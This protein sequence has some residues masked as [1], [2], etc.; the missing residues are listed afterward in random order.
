MSLSSKKPTAIQYKNQ[1]LTEV[2]FEIRFHGEPVVESRRHEFFEKVRGDYPLL[3]VPPFREGIHPSLQ[4]Y[5]FVREDNTAGVTLALNSLGYFQKEYEGAKKYMEEVNRVVRIANK[6]FSIRKFSRIGWRYINT[7]AFTRE[8]GLIPLSYY[9][10]NPPSF[11]T[12][13]SHGFDR[14][15][16]EA[17]TKYEGEYVSVKLQADHLGA[18]GN[19][20]LT[21]DI[22]VYQDESTMEGFTLNRVPGVLERLH[23]IARNFFEESITDDY[24][25]YLKGDT[26]E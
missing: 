7:I 19:E 12:I 16:F 17:T 20:L 14:V 9:F 5:R 26:Y 11:F 23:N 22:D 15:D 3:Y 13:E 24:R 1:P 18:E 25:E 21:F 10:K 8:D 4:H 2:A 6:L